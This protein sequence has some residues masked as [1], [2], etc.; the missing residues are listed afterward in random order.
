M[1][2]EAPQVHAWY[3]AELADGT[4]EAAMRPSVRTTLRAVRR[5]L[6]AETW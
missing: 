1:K 5:D 6:L 4:D 3:Q 2:A